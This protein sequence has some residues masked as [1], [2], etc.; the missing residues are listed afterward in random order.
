MK[1]TES[2]FLRGLTSRKLAAVEALLGSA[3]ADKA[4]A[5]VEQ[6]VHAKR[7]VLLAELERVDAP[8]QKPRA[9]AT[10]KLEAA[11]A[12][13]IAAQTE[14]QASLMAEAASMQTSFGASH[15]AYSARATIEV[16][17]SE[18]SDPRVSR[19]AAILA[20]IDDS[21]RAGLTFYPKKERTNGDAGFRV[22]YSSNLVEVQDARQVIAECST[23]C[24]ALSAGTLAYEE[25]TES[26]VAMCQRLEAP[27]AELALCP[28]Q[29]DDEG[30]VE[31]PLPLARAGGWRVEKAQYLPRQQTPI[32]NPPKSARH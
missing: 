11:V 9:E 18:T 23:Q 1:I 31:M 4:L 24:D 21:V 22:A 29:V 5:D 8:H 16:E 12:R 28:P 30:A 7:R 10:K 6:Q 2:K 20:N 14:L 26:F 27:L 3:V 19:F 13:R 32:E 25:T 15:A 17:L